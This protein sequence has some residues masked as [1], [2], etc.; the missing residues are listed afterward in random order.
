[1]MPVND[2]LTDRLWVSCRSLRGAHQRVKELDV[3]ERNMAADPFRKET[4]EQREE[5]RTNRSERAQQVDE[6]STIMASIAA[7]VDA[8][9]AP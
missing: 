7:I 5:R 4:P 3:A 6:M 2:D 8:A 1:M 9:D